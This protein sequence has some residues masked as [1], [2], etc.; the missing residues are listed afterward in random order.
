MCSISQSTS[1]K[2]NCISTQMNSK[3]DITHRQSGIT[4]ESALAIISVALAAFWIAF[5]Y[6]HGGNTDVNGNRILLLHPLLPIA[7]IVL[8]IRIY[9]WVGIKFVVHLEIIMI[10][11]WLF[12]RMLGVFMPFILG[13]GFAYLFRFLWKA[14]PLKKVYQRAIATV[15]IVLVCSGVLIFTGIRVGT[16]VGQMAQGLQKFFHEGL[17]PLV[18]GEE[19]QVLASD[20][21]D[22][23]ETLLLGTDHGIYFLKNKDNDRKKVDITNGE[24]LGKRINKDNDRKKVGI[25]NG[26][27]LGKR[28][29]DITIGKKYIFA[30]AEGEIYRCS[31]VVVPNQA[32]KK[33][34]SQ[35]ALPEELQWT[36]IQT[37]V[38]DDYSIQSINAPSWDPELIYVG[39]DKG[40]FESTDSGDKWKRVEF[41]DSEDRSSEE[42]SIVSI[43]S[44]EKFEEGNRKNRYIYV[45]STR[46]ILDE[47]ATT[48]NGP[49]ENANN[50]ENQYKTIKEVH[51]RQVN[52]TND[53]ETL[54]SNTD[55]VPEI[56]VLAASYRKGV[57]LYAGTT[58]GMYQRDD[59]IKFGNWAPMQES[60]RLP[61]TSISLLVSTPSALYAG[62][63]NLIYHHT[64]GTSVWKVFTARREGILKYKD[65][66]VVKQFQEY[67]TQKIPGWTASGGAFIRWISGLAGSIAFQFGGF[68]ATVFLAFI[69]FVY[70]SQGFEKY[71]HSFMSLVPEKHRE[72]AMAYLREIDR[73]MH[74]FLKGQFTVIV[75]VSI[76]SCTIY[77]I[78]G[79]PFA[80]LVGILA[81]LCNAIPTFGPFVG[82]GFALIAMLMGL[83]AGEF[84]STFAF[85][86]RCVF[87]LAA[88]LGIQAIDNSLISPKVMS[89]AI[90]V[91]PLLIMFSVIM[92]A[93]ILGL[94]GV[95]LAI[96]IIVVIKSVHAVS[97]SAAN[98][99]D[100]PPAQEQA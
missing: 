9:R 24:L 21:S 50:S 57:L 23:K 10:G 11:L 47:S 37:D 73:N 83:A 45:V 95:L 86:I 77:R 69:V 67:L 14:L 99:V 74:Q 7:L 33:K 49:N 1:T 81:G 78:I 65:E 17:L 13:F 26:E 94:W 79:V 85:L 96:P 19:F 88:I 100:P 32:G 75:I 52:P 35:I 51:C 36:K 55:P 15:L 4:G 16:Q 28:I 80:L 61:Q 48:R 18:L 58:N 60:T 44:I 5:A 30:C 56:Q 8:L 29:K 66:P 62:N 38:F 82:G 97:Q 76:I 12:I 59:N 39:T 46:K 54:G 87:V 98:G 68:L 90:D 6:Y 84:S 42:R 34:K 71:I 25:T 93:S 63:K 43:T 91:D 20:M 27:L 70:A 72:T 92:G 22:D 40:L 89:N 41:G 64:T 31:K 3:N 2:E 53:W